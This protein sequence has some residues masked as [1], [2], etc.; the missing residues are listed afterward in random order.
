MKIFEGYLNKQKELNST[1]AVYEHLDIAVVIPCFNEPNVVSTINNLINNQFRNIFVEIIVVFNSSE[2]AT[3]DQIERNDIGYSQLEKIKTNASNIH[4]RCLMAKGIPV[5]DA[6]VGY[7]RK[8]GMDEAIRLFLAANNPTG[9]I[10]SLDADC[11]VQSNYLQTIYDAFHK[12]PSIN[13]AIIHIEHK[14]FGD[15]NPDLYNA[16]VL[17]EL[18]LRYYSEMLR[19]AGYPYPYITIG[20]GFAV[21]ADAYVKSGGM[22]KKNAGEDFYFLQ[23]L[24]ALNGIKRI[25]NTTVYPEIRD[26]GRVVFGT[27]PALK[28]IMEEGCLKTYSME[29]FIGLKSFFDTLDDLY[30]AEE[31]AINQLIEQ[32]PESIRQFLLVNNFHSKIMEIKKN[33]SSL[34]NFRKRFFSWFNA[35][36]I[37]KFLHYTHPTW[38]GLNNVDVLAR[39]LYRMQCHENVEEISNE[40]LLLKY[41][42]L[43]KNQD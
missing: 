25:N 23:K 8:I 11:L 5:K 6:G 27:G 17:Y 20:S 13:T 1:S 38:Y 14:M 32:Y 33:T 39:K 34:K 41:R 22:N 40:E 19:F 30:A 3:N 18:Y 43:Q 42:N 10:L 9:I 12:H 21:R 24:F 28:K 2:Q 29:A 37:I 31:E 36:L 16:G 26:S 15:K 35:F 7:A 4:I